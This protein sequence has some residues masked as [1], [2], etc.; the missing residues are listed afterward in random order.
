MVIVYPRF[1]GEI[2]LFWKKA[3]KGIEGHEGYKRLKAKKKIRR[4][5]DKRAERF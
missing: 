3:I 5:M 4:L 1:L 2:S